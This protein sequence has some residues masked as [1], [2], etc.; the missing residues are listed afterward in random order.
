MRPSPDSSIPFWQS[1][2]SLSVSDVR[3]R[4][5]FAV[6][7]RWRARATTAESPLAMTLAADADSVFIVASWKGSVCYDQY[8]SPGSFERGLWKQDVAELF[9]QFGSGQRYQEFNLS[10]AG[11]WWTC[12]FVS[13][14]VPRH[15][16]AAFS[17]RI[18]PVECLAEPTANGHE[19]VLC[20][21]RSGLDAP[22]DFPDSI[23][24]NACGIVGG[25]YFSWASIT[26]E[27]PDFHV[28]SRFVP[29]DPDPIQP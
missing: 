28:P 11:A 26:T 22:Q 9:I 18:P 12:S 29:I 20:F 1:E 25:K 10:P 21:P 2:T 15:D 17:G 24:A 7:E 4:P 5:R 13:P 3:R 16:C 27:T 14:R 19:A 23:R 6:E 8:I